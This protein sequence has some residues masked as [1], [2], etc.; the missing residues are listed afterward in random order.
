MVPTIGPPPL[1][2][3]DPLPVTVGAQDATPEGSARS[4]GNGGVAARARWRQHS[5]I[6]QL[7]ADHTRSTELV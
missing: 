3:F 1:A 2:R 4:I 5:L 6:Q 7:A